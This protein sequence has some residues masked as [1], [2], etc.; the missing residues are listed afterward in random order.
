MILVTITSSD[1]CVIERYYERDSYGNVASCTPMIVGP[2][3][4]D[5][6]EEDE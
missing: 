6:E 2:A 1:S 4:V 3:G 5:E